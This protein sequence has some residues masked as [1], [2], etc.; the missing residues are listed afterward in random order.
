MIDAGR[1]IERGTHHQ[2]L[3]LNGHY[4]RMWSGAVARTEARMQVEGQRSTLT[5]AQLA[6]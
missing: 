1:I 6:G 2:L 5:D 3:G 4:A